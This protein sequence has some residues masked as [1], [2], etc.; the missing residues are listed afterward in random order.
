MTQPRDPI[1]DWLGADVELLPPRPGG[2]ERVQRAARHRKAMRAAG[3]AAGTAVVVAAA[4]IAPKLAGALLHGSG[5]AARITSGTTH[6]SPR[7]AS[8]HY[9]RPAQAGPSL[10]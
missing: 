9:A 8:P 6:P 4:V 1:E 3:A 2:F 7:R 5:P 10:T